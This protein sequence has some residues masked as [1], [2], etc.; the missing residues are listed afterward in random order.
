[1]PKRTKRT[2]RAL[3]GASICIIAATYISVNV[4]ENPSISAFLFSNPSTRKSEV[5]R[6]RHRPPVLT[7]GPSWTQDGVEVTT[8]ADTAKTENA[9]EAGELQEE[10]QALKPKTLVETVES[11]CVPSSDLAI[12]CYDLAYQML[13]ELHVIGKRRGLIWAVAHG[14]LL[15]LQRDGQLIGNDHDMDIVYLEHQAA[16]DSDNTRYWPAGRGMANTSAVN[17]YNDMLE[18]GYRITTGG[19]ALNASHKGV[20]E[21]F[22]DKMLDQCLN[23][24]TNFMSVIEFWRYIPLDRAGQRVSVALE[25][26]GD[27]DPNPDADVGFQ[28]AIVAGY[29]DELH[30]K[31]APELCMNHRIDAFIPDCSDNTRS[32]TSPTG[33]VEWNIPFPNYPNSLFLD[34]AYGEQWREPEEL[35]ANHYMNA[36]QKCGSFGAKCKAFTATGGCSQLDLSKWNGSGYNLQEMDIMQQRD[37]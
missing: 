36:P 21:R 35:N 4:F 27:G 16:S 6:G 2:K 7:A 24:K 32:V 22:R 30:G 26:S 20:R 17:T 37:D 19:L 28:K 3:V 23:I 13:C 18:I 29:V 15:A 8:D 34:V 31:T 9:F 11:A 5:K 25:D 10:D 33:Q 14:T 12:D 1:M